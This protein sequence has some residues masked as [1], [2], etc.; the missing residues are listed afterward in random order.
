M[1]AYG[2]AASTTSTTSGAGTAT[3]GGTTAAI[4]VVNIQSTDLEV[5]VAA[6]PTTSNTTTNVTA[7]V[8]LTKIVDTTPPVITM[9]GTAYTTVLQA[10][11]YA[12]QGVRV[13][14]NID[15]N[16]ITV[17]ARLQLCARPATNLSTIA[18]N[19]TRTLAGCGAQLAAINT[20]LPSRSNESF[21]ITYRARD[22]AGNQAAPLR[23]YI[24][25]TARCVVG[26]GQAWWVLC[27][28]R[29]TTA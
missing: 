6:A 5:V 20:T 7:A 4:S 2:A 25:V 14:D 1:S 19:D 17:I 18:A 8:D 3:T 12:D 23:R 16:S 13:Y 10:E 21:V 28:P 22:A 26:Y 15:G 24:T 29:L 9:L 11:R 27:T